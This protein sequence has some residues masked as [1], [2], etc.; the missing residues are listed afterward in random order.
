MSA[1]LLAQ[2]LANGLL[3][4][5]LYAA[6]AAGFSLVWGVLNVVNMLHGSAIVLG[7]YAAWFASARFGVNPFL[8]AIVVGPAIGLLGWAV[9]RFVIQRVITAPVLITL[10]LTFALDLILNNGMINAF[11]ADY[12]KVPPVTGAILTFGP[13]GLP[14]DRVLA[15]VAGVVV[16]LAVH[17]YLNNSRLGR[18]IVAV[19][20]DR[21][22]SMLMG[23]KV[24]HIYA[25]T[26]GL[27]LALAGIAGCLMAVVF[28]ISPLNSSGYLGIAFVACV[29]GGLG[30][31]VGAIVGGIVLGVVESF[32]AIFVGPEY[33]VTVAAVLLIAMLLL[34]PQG[35]LGRAGYE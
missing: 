30:S 35:L 18:A 31:I 27:G 32:G 16:T 20:M 2:V 5:G 11:S 17:A 1:S 8:S 13:I 34:R 7:S 23:V 33:S 21:E 28:P 12:R 22:T 4:G 6:V 3:L 19:R 9:Q 10:V 15:A 14:L 29:L 24:E 25:V 26:F